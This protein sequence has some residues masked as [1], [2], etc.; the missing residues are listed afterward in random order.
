MFLNNIAMKIFVIILLLPLVPFVESVQAEEV[1]DYTIVNYEAREQDIDN[2]GFVDQL[3]IVFNVNTT[4][5][6]TPVSA[7]V[8]TIFDQYPTEHEIVQWD[9]FT[10]TNEKSLSRSI[11]VDAW[12]E[13]DY[14]VTLKFIN[15]I[16]SEVIS[17]Y[18]L[19]V[20]N[21]MVGMEKPFVVL[22][23]IASH[24]GNTVDD[25]FN[26]GSECKIKRNV[27]D[28]I[29]HRYN[30]TGEVQFIGAPWITPSIEP[31][32]NTPSS[33]EIDCSNWPAGKY[34]LKLIYH[35]ALGYSLETWR[36]FSI[37]N[38]PSPSFNLNITGQNMEIGSL[39]FITIEPTDDTD[40][41]ENQISWTT[42]PEHGDSE[43]LEINCKMWMPGIHRI[44]VNVTNSEGISATNGVNLVRI[45]PLGDNSSAWGNESVTSSWPVRSGGEIESEYTGYIATGIGMLLLFIISILVLKRFG[46]DIQGE[47]TKS[48]S[49]VNTDGLPTH[50]DEDGHLWRQHPDGQI[51]WWDADANMWIQFQ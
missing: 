2:D 30:K 4:K 13:G 27:L 15:P 6:Q 50:T 48:K 51:D 49:N 23:V 46:E 29:G 24:E 12:K 11:F 22:N 10:L 7:Q 40:F 37:L 8:K 25:K 47:F 3:R 34:S 19:G 16:T 42:I 36:N 17:E 33:D 20:F 14:T 21:L 38:Q 9:N 1:S 5:T 32:E 28:K 35:N 43:G 31:G 26:T 41:S 44:I 39:C 18:Q 45:P